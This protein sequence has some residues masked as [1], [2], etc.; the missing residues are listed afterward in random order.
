MPKANEHVVVIGGTSGIGLAL[1]AAAG[2]GKLTAERMRGARQRQSDP[3]GAAD[4]DDVLIGL[5]HE[6]LLTLS[7]LNIHDPRGVLTDPVPAQPYQLFATLITP[8]CA[9][10]FSFLSPWLRRA[11]S[12]RATE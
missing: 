5:R 4:D 11:E 10:G 9:A 3:G 7:R 12:R 1:G 6:S 2:N 8:L